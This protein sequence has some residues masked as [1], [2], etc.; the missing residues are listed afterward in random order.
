[1]LSIPILICGC[2]PYLRLR[3]RLGQ[4]HGLARAVRLVGRGVAHAVAAVQHPEAAVRRFSD[5][6]DVG[7]PPPVRR[8]LSALL[9]G[10]G[11]FVVFTKC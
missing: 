7:M 1:M 11:A 6:C 8:S 9:S 10:T 3:R 2:T 4:A 5:A